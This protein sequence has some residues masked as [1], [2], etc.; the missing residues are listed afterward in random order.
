MSTFTTDAMVCDQKDKKQKQDISSK[1]VYE[2]EHTHI[3]TSLLV[4][5]PGGNLS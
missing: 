4:L 2:I 3:S 1:F 5:S